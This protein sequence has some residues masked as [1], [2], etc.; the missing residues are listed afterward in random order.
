MKKILTFF[1]L[2]SFVFLLNFLILGLTR[3]LLPYWTSF[4]IICLVIFL[5]NFFR[6][7]NKNLTVTFIF[8]GV[9]LGCLGLCLF[10]FLITS[11]Y[12]IYK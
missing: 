8:M 12:E 3:T 6:S 11:G 4:F 1:L 5:V 7:M 2:V 10:S 9:A